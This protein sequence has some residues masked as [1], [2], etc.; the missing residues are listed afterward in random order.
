MKETS[1]HILTN[2]HS[3]PKIP[4]RMSRASIYCKRSSPAYSQRN[5]KPSKTRVTT[6]AFTT[7]QHLI[8]PR[9][10]SPRPAASYLRLIDNTYF[11][12]LPALLTS[13]HFTTSPSYQLPQSSFASLSTPPTPSRNQNLEDGWDGGWT[14]RPRLI[15]P[16]CLLT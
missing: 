9:H 11:S 8:T 7:Q 5:N 4:R 12:F 10:A 2:V 1:K 14:W 16:V 13:L 15:C 6:T 3:L